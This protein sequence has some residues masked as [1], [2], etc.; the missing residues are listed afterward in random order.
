MIAACADIGLSK[1][2]KPKNKEGYY[3]TGIRIKNTINEH[4]PS[5]GPVYGFCLRA[6]NGVVHY[7][8]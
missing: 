5:I 8:G 6:S 3:Q 1:L 2:T 4:L 7:C